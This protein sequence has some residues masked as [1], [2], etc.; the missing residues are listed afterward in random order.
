[1]SCDFIKDLF[2]RL[3]EAVQ[4]EGGFSE[5]LAREVAQ[6]L[7]HDWGGD[8]VY[9]AKSG[10]DAQIEMTRRNQSI[11]RDLNNGERVGLVA[12]RYKISRPMVYKIWDSYLKS[13]R[14]YV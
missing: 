6:Q 8:R 1:M 2:T 12:N 14:R 9:I 7:R 11:I 10:E 5:S 4:R 13:R 3:N